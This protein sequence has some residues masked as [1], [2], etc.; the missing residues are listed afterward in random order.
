MG[1]N[2]SVNRVSVRF[3]LTLT[4]LK[5]GQFRGFSPPTQQ[6]ANVGANGAEIIA[7]FLNYRGSVPFAPT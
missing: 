6:L 1:N 2:R 5:T 7:V 4:T 3:A